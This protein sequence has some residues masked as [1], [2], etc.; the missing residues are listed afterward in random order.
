[1]LREFIKNNGL[2]A[3]VER[4]KVK[5]SRHP[6][7]PN[8]VLLKYDQINSPMGDLLAQECRGLILNEDDDW[9]VVSF[10]Y[11]KFFNN[12]EG[13]AKDL[14]WNTAKVYE[15]LDGSIM[16]LYHYQDKWHVS[17]S[18]S[19]DAGGQVTYNRNKTFQELFWEVWNELG[20][21]LPDP[22]LN[23]CYMFELMTAENRIVVAYDFNRLVLHGARCILLPYNEVAPEQVAKDNGWE[24]VKTF[25]FNDL[26]NVLKVADTLGGTEGEGFVVCDHRFHRQKIKGKA[27]V[28][29]HHLKS[30]LSL[31]RIVEIVQANEGEEF[32]RYFPEYTKEFTE[33][34]EKFRLLYNK[35]EKE[36]QENKDIE[37][38]KDFALAIKHLPYSGALFSV[39]AEKIESVE[40]WLRAHDSKKVLRLLGM[41]D[42]EFETI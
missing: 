9:N 36:Y 10:P 4:T 5:T 1:M 28:A 38:Q 39:R 12:G 40:A 35:A 25:P 11:T 22:A 13:H 23:M 30:S 20:Y 2:D 33:I 41:A 16:T 17:S 32:L 27:Y 24:C 31:R 3:L 34:R 18:G 37:V 19:P 8:L 6:L 21:K 29:L 26:A 42:V 7:F 15:K 14:D